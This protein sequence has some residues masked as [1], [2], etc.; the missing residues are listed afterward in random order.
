MKKAKS[1]S[2]FI[3]G[4]ATGEPVCIE[5]DALEPTD[6]V[7]SEDEFKSPG[8]FTHEDFMHK[9]RRAPWCDYH[10][11]HPQKV[12]EREEEIFVINGEEK[13]KLNIIVAEHECEYTNNPFKAGCM[14]SNLSFHFYPDTCGTTTIVR[15]RCGFEENITDYDMY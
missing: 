8:K 5:P 7:I 1:M 9:G 4:C 2:E 13:R 14:G 15:C 12:L 11:S 3:K 10:P 6:R